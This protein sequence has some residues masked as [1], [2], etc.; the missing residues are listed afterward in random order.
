MLLNKLL[1]SLRAGLFSNNEFPAPVTETEILN[2][3]LW[4]RGKKGDKINL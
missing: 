3:N 4:K 2:L 1:K